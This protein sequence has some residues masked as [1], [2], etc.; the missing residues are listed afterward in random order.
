MPK[1]L[2]IEIIFENRQPKEKLIC[3]ES[4]QTAVTATKKKSLI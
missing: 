4:L 2:G 3:I 1:D